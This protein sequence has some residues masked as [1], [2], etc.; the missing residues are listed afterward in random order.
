MNVAMFDGYF[1]L[2]KSNQ[3]LGV[4]QFRSVIET[5]VLLLALPNVGEW[6]GS[7]GGYWR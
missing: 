7:A 5:L 4:G 6:I 3:F 2:S 1:G